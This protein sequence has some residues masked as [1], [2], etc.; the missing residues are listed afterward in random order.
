MLPVLCSLSGPPGERVKLLARESVTDWKSDQIPYVLNGD[1]AS[2]Q[3]FTNID[4]FTM[5]YLTRRQ[6]DGFTNQK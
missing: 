4:P 3:V 2:L 6:I 1:W 5:V